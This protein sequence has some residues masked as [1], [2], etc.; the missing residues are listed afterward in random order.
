MYHSQCN[1]SQR[2]RAECSVAVAGSLLPK[3]AFVLSLVVSGRCVCMWVCGVCGVCVG[4]RDV[5]CAVSVWYVGVFKLCCEILLLL[6]V[7]ESD[8]DCLSCGRLWSQQC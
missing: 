8:M 5:W 4:V 1:V 2:A 7:A 6:N 3:Y